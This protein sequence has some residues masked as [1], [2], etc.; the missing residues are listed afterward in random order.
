MKFRSLLLGHHDEH[1]IERLSST[2]DRMTPEMRL[3][4][5]LSIKPDEQRMLWDLFAG[6][7][8]S[9]EHFVPSGTPPL[10]SVICHGRNTLPVAKFFQKRFYRESESAERLAGYNHQR[11]A[12]L[13]GP[14]Y[15]IVRPD[16]G[17]GGGVLIDYNHVPDKPP[18]GGPAITKNDSGIGRLVY[19][20]MID[21]L[22]RVSEH[23]VIG[24][25]FRGGEAM[26]D[27]FVLCRQSE[28]ETHT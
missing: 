3:E 12:P 24:R 19:G 15:F 25:A 22:R 27:Y 28:P 8:V 10:R 9:F 26:G 5:V 4:T 7:T 11:L 17:D 20:G 13:T 23:V 18:T 2:L 6:K 16:D 21:R 14:G 1:A